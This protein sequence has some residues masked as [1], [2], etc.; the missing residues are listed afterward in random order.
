[1]GLFSS[2]FGAK[3]NDDQGANQRASI[4]AL[5]AA[6]SAGEV[7]I[8]KSLI[9]G[10]VDVNGTMPD[11]MTALAAAVFRKQPEAAKEL[12]AAG[13]DVLKR[14]GDHTVLELATATEQPE[15]ARLIQQAAIKQHPGVE[16]IEGT[17]ED[18]IRI[19]EAAQHE[20]DQFVAA[21]H[22]RA[23]TPGHRFAVKV[24][25]KDSGIVEHIWVE[26]TQ[27]NEKTIV[28]TIANDPV[29]LKVVKFGDF[30]H[31]SIDRVEDITI[32]D[33][34]NRIVLGGRHLQRLRARYSPESMQ[35]ILG[36][37]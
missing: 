33:A 22:K 23:S 20:M 21:F 12:I 32:S 3:K 15:L 19:K 35:R 30:Y 2:L 9:R 5:V 10:G 28:G 25:I 29:N 24:P 26:V 36:A 37:S 14:V 18:L 11:G 13:A 4:A 34:Q 17:P 31:A 7:E 16:Q 8:M 27:I 1:M 6:A